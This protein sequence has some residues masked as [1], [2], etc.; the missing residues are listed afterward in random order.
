[1][2]AALRFLLGLALG[3]CAGFVHAQNN[4]QF[5]SQSVPATMTPGQTYAVSITMRNTGGTTWTAA[6]DYKLGSENPPNN[7]TWGLGRVLLTGP[8]APGQDAVFS[9][10]VTAPATAG[11]YNFQWKML[12]ELVEWFGPLTPNVVVAVGNVDYAQFISQ[13]V[14]GS[15][16][17]SQ[18]YAVSVTMKNAGGTTW[19]PGE[20][21][22]RSQ[23]PPDN[24]NW[25]LTRVELASAVAPGAN[26]TF[27]FNVSSPINGNVNFRWQMARA[28]TSF[29]ELTPNVAVGVSG[30]N[31]AQFISQSV[32]AS[33]AAGQNYPVT[34]TMRNSGTN[35][36]ALAHGHGIGSQNPQDNT[37][38][39]TNRIYIA[40]SAA[41][42]QDAIFSFNVRAPSTAGTY[43]FQWRMIRE[44]IEWFGPQT[45]NLAIPVSLP[46]A[47]FVSQSVPS[48]MVQG[49]SSPVS[50]TLQNT[51][52]H[53]WVPGQYYLRSQNPQDN[54][55]WGTSRAELASAVPPGQ[56]GTFS[57]NVTP[58]ATGT[59]NFQWRMANPGMSFGATTPNLAVTVHPANAAAFVSQVVPS[60]L[61]PGQTQLVRVTMQNTSNV[62]WTT[63]A[64]YQLGSQ[65]PQDNTAWGPSRV[66]LPH[67]VPPGQSVAFVFPV[68]APA[69]AGSHNFQWK[70]LHDGVGW[71]GSSS[72]N[73]AV[74][75]QAQGSVVHYIHVD[76]LNTPRLVANSSGTPVWKWEQQEPF[77]LNAPDENPSSLGAFEFP[78]R[79][80]GQYADK[81]T[82]L[83]YNYF[84]DYDSTI[85]R[86]IES[87]PIGLA[88]GLNTYTYVTA[89]PIVLIDPFG[90]DTPDP[91]PNGVVPLPKGQ[92][93]TPA[94]PNA[95][96]PPLTFYG[97]KQKSG[98][99]AMCV[100]VPP[101]GPSNSIGYWKFQPAGTAGW[102]QRY[103]AGP[104][105][106]SYAAG[107][108]ITPQQAHPGGVNKILKNVKGAVRGSND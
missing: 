41:P 80:P 33:M 53:A 42:G 58:A 57:F 101:G 96:Q 97:P 59:H 92:K 69:T 17:A 13:S 10:N 61:A 5:I 30:T 60:S 71:F 25:G 52:S 85:G 39:G 67:D 24:N 84:R 88:G 95:M 65:N 35:T 2:S 20:Y 29:G 78:L 34:I 38:W 44:L 79:F 11:L 3:L 43:N 14:P 98:M 99:Q 4:A 26:A 87:D 83:Y 45:P 93:W 107:T 77:G 49:V 100:F 48:P 103:A 7:G 31:A 15:M 104:P 108:P 55:F 51:G 18:S 81:E 37:T 94:P 105:Y 72:A 63:A 68:T 23:N 22:L 32:P 66:A 91:D 76:H 9:F 16:T 36:W 86:Y 89:N 46:N 54:T 6:T 75:V 82:N 50:V 70:M 28:T 102:Q 21:Y 1:M 56:N 62:T 40:G 8:V 12:R 106:G 64:G 47:A 27:S 74:D 19:N 73:V 90:L